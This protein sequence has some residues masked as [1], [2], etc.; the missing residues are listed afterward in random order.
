MAI[1]I[2]IENKQ[3]YL[4]SAIAVFLLGVGLVMG[5]WDT[6]KTLFHNAEDVKV[7]IDGTDYSLQEAIDHYNITKSSSTTPLIKT[8][9][10][11]GNDF[12]QDTWDMMCPVGY[13]AI[14][15]SVG[16]TES[17]GTADEITCYL[18]LNLENDGCSFH[19]DKDGA[20][21]LDPNSVITSC[22]CAKAEIVDQT[23]L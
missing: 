11:R 8:Y 4:F 1:N 3:L 13:R 18:Y 20:G 9:R 7:N 22:T 12:C 16:H 15:C 2:K 17:E 5:D 6:T 10:D 21:W 14:A 23:R 19:W